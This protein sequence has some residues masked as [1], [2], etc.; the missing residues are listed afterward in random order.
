MVKF[1]ETKN[2]DKNHENEVANTD[3]GETSHIDLT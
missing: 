1:F 2:Y 3:I